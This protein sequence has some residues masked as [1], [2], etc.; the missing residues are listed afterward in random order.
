MEELH[1]SPRR[2]RDAAMIR[3][4]MIPAGMGI[5]SLCSERPM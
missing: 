5:R 2:K 1:A 3:F 4:R